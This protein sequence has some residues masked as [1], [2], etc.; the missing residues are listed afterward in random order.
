[1]IQ[2]VCCKNDV[3][4]EEE[5]VFENEDRFDEDR[6]CPSDQFQWL[7]RFLLAYVTRLVT[8]ERRET[9]V[10]LLLLDPLWPYSRTIIGTG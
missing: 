3:V 7:V 1:M 8:V 10:T 4:G 5:N 9:L 2:F 6:L